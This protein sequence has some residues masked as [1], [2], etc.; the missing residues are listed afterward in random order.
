MAKER[1]LSKL[2]LLP[3]L[4][5]TEIIL[6]LAKNS[7]DAVRNILAAIP[8]LAQAAN[9]P[10]VFRNLNLYLLTV[11]S[12]SLLHSYQNLMDLCLSAGNLEAHYLR[13]MQE[14]IQ[15][16][17]ITE[18]F[19]HLQ[20]A[21]QGLYDNAIYL[22]GIIMLSRGKPAIGKLLSDSLGWIGN[23]ARA[24]ACWKN[25]KTSIHGVE[26]TRFE[27]Y[28]TTYRGTRTTRT[29]HRDNITYMCDTCY[30]LKQMNKIS[31]HYLKQ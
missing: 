30:Y 22:Y 2:E 14:Y 5:Q 6:R 19:V 27:I 24:D 23:K 31:F 3:I 28:M 4:I 7:R 15:K 12:L 21:A 20:I 11:Q 9:S 8:T 17:N 16:E 1:S 29:C 25:I 13:G 10:L 26:V 18:W